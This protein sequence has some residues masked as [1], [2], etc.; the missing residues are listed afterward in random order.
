MIN[1]ES[2]TFTQN[3]FEILAFQNRKASFVGVKYLR[4]SHSALIQKLFL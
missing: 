3:N 4:L 1:T 2:L